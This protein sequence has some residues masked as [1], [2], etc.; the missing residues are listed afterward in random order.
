MLV[1]PEHEHNIQDAIVK[2]T[3]SYAF[4]LPSSKAAC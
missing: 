3:M 4:N 1:L 2:E